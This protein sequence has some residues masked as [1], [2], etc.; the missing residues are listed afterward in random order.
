MNKD[1]QR[2][3]Q[4]MCREPQVSY[5]RL[6]Q[7]LRE[8][9][10]AGDFNDDLLEAITRESAKRDWRCVNLLVGIVHW[11]PE[12]RFTP[13]LCELLDN[14]RAEVNVEVIADTLDYLE[15]GRAV[16]ALVRALNYFV[17]G[18]DSYRFNKKVLSALARTGSPEAV[19]GLNSALQSSEVEIRETAR[20]ELASLRPASG[21]T[22]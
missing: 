12:P 2:L 14:H 16:P 3:Y 18:D 21:A 15:D 7:I 19:E 5:D 9:R 1:F 6:Q 10:R 11:N 4:E 13:L 17:P 22:G 20:E 8:L